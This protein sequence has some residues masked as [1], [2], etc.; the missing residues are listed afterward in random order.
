[1]DEHAA[2]DDRLAARPVDLLEQL[3]H[4]LGQH[5][6]RAKVRQAACSG[7]PRRKCGVRRKHD[8]GRAQHPVRRCDLAVADAQRGRLLVDRHAG[9]KR[10]APQRAHEQAGMHGRAVAEVDAASEDGRAH[11]L[12]DLVR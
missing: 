12:R 11:A 5:D 9:G 1:V 2:V 6:V 7:S 8:L 3:R 10:V 4:R